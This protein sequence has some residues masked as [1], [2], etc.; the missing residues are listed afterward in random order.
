MGL[1]LLIKSKGLGRLSV[2]LDPNP[3]AHFDMPNTFFQGQVKAV[4][5]FSSVNPQ[6]NA[7]G[8]SLLSLC[9]FRRREVFLILNQVACV[10]G[11]NDLK[12]KLVNVAGGTGMWAVP[13]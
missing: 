12:K 4:F 5:P 11:C 7:F 9:N 2:G 8:S 3:Q 1:V 10:D 13:L 6:E